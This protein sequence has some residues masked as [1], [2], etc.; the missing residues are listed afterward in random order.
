MSVSNAPLR[1][2]HLSAADYGGAGIA[3][4]RF[5]EHMLPLGH[6]SALLVLSKRSREF[7][8]ESMSPRSPWVAHR[9]STAASHACRRVGRLRSYPL[10]GFELLTLGA[11]SLSRLSEIYAASGVFACPSVEGSAPMIITESLMSGTLGVS[12]AVGVAEDLIEHRKKLMD[13]QT[14]AT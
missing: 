8:G 4:L 1:M 2:L 14:C 13:C 9:C 12:L 6:R 5:H 10:L 3:A 11:V 7:T